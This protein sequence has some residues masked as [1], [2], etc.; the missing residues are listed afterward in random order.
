MLKNS[1]KIPDVPDMW[2][3]SAE[4]LSVPTKRIFK[5]NNEENCNYMV[6][7]FMFLKQKNVNKV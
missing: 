1:E 3:A 7:V 6:A 4:I 5:V 2:K